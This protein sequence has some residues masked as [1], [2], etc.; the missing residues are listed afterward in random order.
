MF[1][2]ILESN[3][4][5]AAHKLARDRYGEDI[6]VLKCIQDKGRY[7]ILVACD[8][9]PQSASDSHSYRRNKST[10]LPLNTGN[11]ERLIEANEQ[12]SAQEKAR[13]TLATLQEI[14]KEQNIDF[15]EKRVI[16]FESE[17][18]RFEFSKALHQSA[19]GFEF[20]HLL[21]D[22]SAETLKLSEVNS[23][24]FSI[25]SMSG[26][27]NHIITQPRE[28]IVIGTALIDEFCNLV[29]T[30]NPLNLKIAIVISEPSVNSFS[31]NS[32]YGAIDE[33]FIT[34][35]SEFSNYLNIAALFSRFKISPSLGLMNNP[36]GRL[37]TLNRDVIISRA[38][39]L[40]SNEA[41]NPAIELKMALSRLS[42]KME[43][44]NE[45]Y[46][47]GRS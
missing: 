9:Q 30:F 26:L 4:L 37:V 34:G 13:N 17:Q 16:F 35:L 15:R 10:S 5:S 20:V 27:L 33:I 25:D 42:E 28:S 24:D 43:A 19:S 21:G 29:D 18:Q 41:P 46:H 47:H 3:S 44:P 8:E 23:D 32:K 38:K 40:I 6:F 2:E 11:Q 39:K 31:A 45:G 7:K 36:S 14:P 22:K 12:A 1:I